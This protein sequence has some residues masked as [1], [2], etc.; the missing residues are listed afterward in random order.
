[1]SDL[2]QTAR[3]SGVDR[4]DVEFESGGVT[5]RG[6]LFVPPT[7]AAG[8]RLPA[9]VMAEGF[10]GVKEIGLELFAR[11]LAAEGIATLGFDYPC[12]GASDG[13][14]RQRLDPK[15]QLRA[16]RDGLSYA[17]GRDEI[18]A[19][20]LGLWGASFAGGHVLSLCADRAPVRCAMAVVP[21][22][23]ATVD[24]V[25]VQTL[26]GIRWGVPHLL[27]GRVPVVASDTHAFAMMPDPEAYATLM[28]VAAERA[29]AYRN[30]ITADSLPR[31][32]RYRPAAAARRIRT[33]V[34]LVSM[35]EDVVTPPQPVRRIARALGDRADLQ[36][37]TGTHFAILGAQLERVQALT[38]EWFSAQ[39]GVSPR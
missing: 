12:F 18:D 27:R 6:W 37:L 10:A 2:V 8:R 22:L 7:G 28:A 3:V 29:P 33:P 21:F 13:G 11:P 14:P 32:A 39:L 36:E 15:A 20:R 4:R 35:S 38:V 5:L 26:R 31:I 25:A 30:W 9:V 24:D 16:Y 17:A 19:D 34:R 1:M 23:G